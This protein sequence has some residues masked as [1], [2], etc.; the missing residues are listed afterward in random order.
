[1]A[2]CLTAPSHYLNQW[3]SIIKGVLW[4]SLRNLLEMFINIIRYMC[5]QI[6]L[7]KSF[8]H[9]PGANQ[10]N[11]QHAFFFY[12]QVKSCVDYCAGT[13][14]MVLLYIYFTL[15]EINILIPYTH[16]LNVTNVIKI[17]L[18]IMYKI[19]ETLFWSRHRLFCI[20]LINTL[21]SARA[22]IDGLVQD[23]SIA[24]AFAMEILQY[25]TKL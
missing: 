9:L 4:H 6:T 18:K 5:S 2:C 25:C 3:W 15:I 8:P 24:S 22:Y 23:C 14:G 21:K 10:L 7:L 20:G 19:C 16:I 17:L 11:I 13:H 1:M 12:L